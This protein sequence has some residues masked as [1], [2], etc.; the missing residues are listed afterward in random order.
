MSFLCLH[1]Y[2]SLTVWWRRSVCTSWLENGVTRLIAA[3]WG[4]W[5]I[6]Q[7]CDRNLSWIQLPVLYPCDGGDYL[8]IC[9]IAIHANWLLLTRKI[10]WTID[11]DDRT[12]LVL[13]VNCFSKRKRKLVCCF[14][15]LF[16]VA[17]PLV[18]MPCWKSNATWQQH[19]MSWECVCLKPNATWQEQARCFPGGCSGSEAWWR[20]TS[21]SPRGYNQ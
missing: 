8:N 11:Y 20:L 6:S 12:S 15:Q 19:I 5:L 9:I 17:Q 21:Q 2:R 4:T 13:I 7:W 16:W 1:S 10:N 3:F 14:E 18:P